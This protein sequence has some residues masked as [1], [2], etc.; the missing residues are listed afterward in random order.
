MYYDGDDPALA[1]I[2]AVAI[3][4]LTLCSSSLAGCPRLQGAFYAEQ[5]ER[6]RKL[7]PLS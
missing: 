7:L 5:Q 4:L 1:I 3:C 6:G 2:S